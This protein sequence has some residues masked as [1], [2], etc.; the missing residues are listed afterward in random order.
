MKYTELVELQDNGI[1][2][3]KTLDSDKVIIG[4]T[5]V[6]A[7]ELETIVTNIGWIEHKLPP[8]ELLRKTTKFLNGLR[9]HLKSDSIKEKMSFEFYNIA[10]SEYGKTFDRIIVTLPGNNKITIIYGMP[11]NP[12]AYTIYE[13]GKANCIGKCRNLSEVSK[14]IEQFD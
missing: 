5:E 13:Y 10:S 11:G 3:I 6:T 14:F 12:A 7:S 1:L 9:K 2:N 8:K 4:G